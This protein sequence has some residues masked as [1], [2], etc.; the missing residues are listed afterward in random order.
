MK[1][2]F[3]IVIP[4]MWRSSN[5]LKMIPKYQISEY[6]KEIIII[7]NDPQN[8][9][10]IESDDKII[11]H[12]EGKNI[13][14]NPAWNVGYSYSN[15][16]LILANDDILIEDI[17]SVLNLIGDSDYDIIGV[18]MGEKTDTMRVDPIEFQPTNHF[19]SFMY[20]KNYI[21]IPEQ[22]KIWYGDDILFDGNPKRGILIDGGITSN[23][24]A[25]VK[26]FK[27]QKVDNILDKDK[28]FYKNLYTKEE[29]YNVITRTSGR[30]N[31]FRNCIR[32]VK[33]FYPSAKLHITID[34]ESDLEYVKSVVNEFDY[35]YY[36][37]NP[38]TVTRISKK[39][40]LNRRLFIYNYYFN[41]V[42]PFLNGWCQYLDDD[43]E[44][45]LTATFDYN[46]K[47]TINLFRSDL[48]SRIVPKP[49]N[50][51]KKPVLNDISTLCVIVHSSK[52]IDWI[53]NR[54]G[55][56]DFIS[57]LYNQNN[58]VWHSEILAK[59]QTS[60]N[61]GN[62]NDR[63]DKVINGFYLNLDKRHDRKKKMEVEVLKTKHNIARYSAID[64]NT[65]N[66]LNG[67]AGSIKGSEYKQYATY[68]SH[69]NML[70][71]ANNNK[72]TELLILEDDITLCEDFDDRLNLFMS[73]LPS[74]WKIAYI[75]FNG[76][77]NSEIKQVSK[78]IYSVKN[79]YGCFGMIINGDFLPELISIVEKNKVAIDHVIHQFVQPN[80]SCYSFIPF[81]V[82]VN[83][84]YS[85]LWNKVRVIDVIKNL[86]RKTIDVSLD[87]VV[88]SKH[89]FG[90]VQGN[91]D[92]I[93]KQEVRL[94]N[95]IQNSVEI[96]VII[97]TFDNVEFIVECLD[98]VLESCRV[99]EKFEILV[100]IDACEKT[101]KFIKN[102]KFDDSITF[103]F[104]EKNVGPYVIKNSLSSI[105]KYDKL[106]FFDS[107]DVME[108]NMI[109]DVIDSLIKYDFC[110]PKFANFNHGGMM[111]LNNKTSYG[112]GVF[113]IRRKVFLG[114]KGFQPWRCAAD[115]EFMNRL[116]K[117]KLE[118]RNIENICFQRRIHDKS[119]TSSPIT[120]FGS[121]M[122]EEYVKSMR[123]E[124]KII[125]DKLYVE[126]F[127]KISEVK[128]DNEKFKS[129]LT[130][131]ENNDLPQK[132]YTQEEKK[133]ITNKREIIF[134]MIR[135]KNL[136]V[137][138]FLLSLY[139]L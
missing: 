13:Y 23:E 24:S 106:I 21:Y 100:G 59:V 3:S 25:T 72:W 66:N 29:K 93:K 12:T 39:K 2:E 104:F 88:N 133:I 114:L 96:S 11:Y 46:D 101:L 48:N 55:D 9:F 113:G 110:K 44:M 105:S 107:D 30:N 16:E 38:E 75:G 73:N 51:G 87:Y 40:K 82:Y 86:Y 61:F 53:P 1:K 97:P 27:R 10:E 81:L 111:R 64:G 34:N 35:N 130:K 67:F 31:Y 115:S 54:G 32:S 69:L 4:T 117:S 62:R 102:K 134:S 7:D 57:G 85:D 129:N 132:K 83:D 128:T 95:N 28:I 122:R 77:H 33:R 137:N 50:Y 127:L 103:Y 80:Y 99:I 125:L 89:P 65:L 123:R 135:K 15:Y 36:L 58:V 131:T 20:V 19:G 47:N 18:R 70:K 118:F 68:L 90:I 14:V 84:D 136:I 119:L 126:K 124:L 52:I 49:E 91:L 108:P 120:G 139:C 5:I 60:E 8:K 98:S 109:K 45:C 112:E 79:V 6:V 42:K 71:I 41:I 76:Q 37:I 17:D 22:I 63:Q 74:D 94:N 78:W 26:E 92:E 116:Y 43:D 121:E 138:Y 56:F